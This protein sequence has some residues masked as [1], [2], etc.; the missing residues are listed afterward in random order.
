MPDLD[1]GCDGRP[2]KPHVSG[3]ASNVK[4]TYASP[5]LM[6]NTMPN[7]L[8]LDICKSQ[9][10]IAGRMAKMKSVPADHAKQRVKTQLPHNTSWNPY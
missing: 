3:A 7:L 1:C 10:T 5:R 4:K 6:T 2:V 9:I 8:V